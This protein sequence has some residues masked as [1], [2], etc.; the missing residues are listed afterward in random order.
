MQKIKPTDKVITYKSELERKAEL[1][2]SLLIMLEEAATRQ[3]C[4]EAACVITGVLKN[5]SNDFSEIKSSVD[6]WESLT[7]SNLEKT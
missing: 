7:G 3:S 1:S 4:E 2:N 5:L 6:F